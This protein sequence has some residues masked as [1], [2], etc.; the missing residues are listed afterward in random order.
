MQMRNSWKA[1]RGTARLAIFVAG[2][3]LLAGCA[4][5]Y[6]FV[7]PD[8]AGGG[9]YYTS[10][11]PYASQGYY[12]YYG[13]GPY[14]PAT[15]GWGYYGGT[16]PYSD[17]YGWYGNYGY[18]SSLTFGFG[19]SSVWGFPGY[20]GPWYSS[21]WGCGGGYGCGGWRHRRRHDHH[22]HDPATPKPWL[23]PDH[24]P[25]PPRIAHGSES[26]MP[27]ARPIR[28]M[29]RRPVEGF[30]NRRPLGAAALNPGDFVRAP[31]GRSVGMGFDRTSMRPAYVPRVPEESAFANRRELPVMATPRAPRPIAQ[32]IFRPAPAPVV[33]VV[34]LPSRS[35]RTPH[36][37]VQ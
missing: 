34:S 11:G 20:W 36:T 25:M 24:P 9:G 5:N 29:V 4:T 23:Q 17:P 22:N 28:P 12:D 21:N 30:A 13:T 6:S 14:Y 27:I 7:Q 2:A 26:A 31:T 19:F 15:S 1:I 8:M 32:P 16:W 10:D 33:P 18:G 35:E 3:L 37:K